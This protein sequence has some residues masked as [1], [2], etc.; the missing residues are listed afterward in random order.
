MVKVAC[1]MPWR[2]GDYRREELQDFVVGWI[3]KHHH[4]GVHFGTS[5]DGPFNRGAAINFGALG[6]EDW[7][8]LIVHDADNICDPH[9]LRDAINHA[10]ITGQV[11]YPYKTY[12]YLDKESSTRIMYGDMWFLSP[13]VHPTQ[14]FRT[15]VRHKH[16]SGIQVIPRSAYE[17]VGGFIE[18]EGWGAEDAIMDILFTL[19]AAGSHWLLGGAYHLWHP[20]NRNDPKD[21]H[22]VS[23]H[24]V[25]SKLKRSMEMNRVDPQQAARITLSR[26]GHHIP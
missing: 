20:A 10:H 24:E 19:F 2:A 6:A 18:L 21:I 12:T 22:N 1:V 23:N 8:I 7:D 9:V 5:P 3:L 25:L 16:Y 17:A 11:T 15:T 4:W 13:E 14:V 26:F